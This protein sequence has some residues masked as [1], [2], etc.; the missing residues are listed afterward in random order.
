MTILHKVSVIKYNQVVR[1]NFN[2]NGS[3]WKIVEA[4]LK[5]P[6]SLMEPNEKPGKTR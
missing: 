5:I 2:D 4:R 6:S 3:S 1:I